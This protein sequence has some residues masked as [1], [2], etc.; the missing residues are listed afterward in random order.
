MQER[1]VAELEKEFFIDDESQR[2]GGGVWQTTPA[3]LEV[4]GLDRNLVLALIEAH[5][6]YELMVGIVLA[7]T[8]E[9][10]EQAEIDQAAYPEYLPKRDEKG[11]LIFDEYLAARF[12]HKVCGL[13]HGQ[14]YAWLCKCYMTERRL[15]LVVESNV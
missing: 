8:A 9:E 1:S 6:R 14:A 10:H 3:E 4:F 5:Y 2:H 11:G 15:G 13:P 7:T 12:M